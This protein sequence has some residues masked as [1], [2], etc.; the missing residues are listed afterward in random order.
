MPEGDFL[1]LSDRIISHVHARTG[2]RVK[3]FLL[4]LSPDR[5]VL[6]GNA[7]SFHVKQL[8]QQG[9]RELLPQLPLQN[10]IAVA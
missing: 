9:V 8:A 7:S 6:Q 4:E 5:V 2:G 1:T 3:N 10:A